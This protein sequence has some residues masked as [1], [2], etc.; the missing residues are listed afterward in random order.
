MRSLIDQFCPNFHDAPVTAA[1]YDPWSGTTATAD[2]N[3]VVAVQRPGEASPQLFFQPGGPIHG[4]LALIRGGTLVA[5]GD[6]DGSVGVFSTADGSEY[7]REGREG[8][9]GRVRAMRGI[10]I[11]P[12][13]AMLASIAKDRFV[14]AWDLTRGE[15]VNAWQGFAG[16][17]VAFDER[18][19]RLLLLDGQG[20]PRLFDLLRV[21]TFAMDHLQTPADRAIFTLDGTLVLAAGPAGIAL[22][23]VA[24]GAMVA[25]FATQGGTGIMNLLISPDNQ[26]CAV[27]TQRSVHMFSLPDLQPVDSMRHGA[28]EPSGAAAWSH[29]GVRVG[30]NDGLL[31]SGKGSAAGG[32]SLATGFGE[33]R[34]AVHNE[35]VAHWKSG[36]RKV[37]VDVGAPI[38]D[39]QI[40]RDGRIIGVLP[41]R[42]PIVVFDVDNG[43][44]VFEAS[45]DTS[46]ASQLC[47]GGTVIAARMAKGGCRWWDLANNKGFELAWPRAVALS[48]GGTWLGVVTPKGAVRILNPADGR[49]IM[50]GPVPGGPSPVQLLS[51][52]NRRP[53]L[54][55]FDE[56]GILSHYD[57]T[58]AGRG[59]PG[60]TARDILSI[61]APVDRLWGITGG[62]RCALRL[63]EGE[64]CT[65][66]FVDLRSGQ[67]SAELTGLHPEATVDPETG[68]VLQPAR[69]AAVLESDMRAVEKI[70]LRALPGGE[71]I[72]FGPRG[73]VAASQSAGGA[74]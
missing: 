16:D 65:L 49:E 24:D 25:S 56:E 14:R 37:E 38:A 73:I 57:L 27:V 19:E 29:V 26:R 39:A 13:G 43:K 46:G 7:F 30:G 53:D 59:G 9:R 5:V 74:I 11:S 17:S 33:H 60:A 3:G 63:P 18:G 20:Q 51:F 32:V 70:V 6:E 52:V 31:H 64:T 22:L 48:G 4:A 62:E 72:S 54:L 66:L 61:R 47:V 68:D 23:R 55:V 1:A 50:K 21:Q 41:K 67:L 36:A 45:P 35:R 42:G 71:W 12:D 58:E 28:P 44:K 40:D 69:S 34:L 8:G 2:A 15:R 10:A